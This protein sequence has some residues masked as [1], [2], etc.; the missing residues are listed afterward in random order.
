MKIVDKRVKSRLN[1]IDSFV[2]LFINREYKNLYSL[3]SKSDNS[4]MDEIL[5]VIGSF[6]KLTN[7]NFNSNERVIIADTI[8]YRILYGYDS[9]HI[10]DSLL[11][12][13][14]NSS[15]IVKLSDISLLLSCKERPIFLSLDKDLF[16]WNLRCIL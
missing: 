16:N 9:I 4:N 12:T 11:E 10:R 13:I 14:D 3:F 15:Y 6:M 8:R 5:T 1:K 7:Y 2:K